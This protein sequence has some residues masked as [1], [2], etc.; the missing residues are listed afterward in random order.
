MK[1]ELHRKVNSRAAPD[2]RLIFQ[3]PQRNQPIPNG[4]GGGGTSICSPTLRAVDRKELPKPASQELR[5]VCF[6]YCD[7]D[8]D[9]GWDL[10]GAQ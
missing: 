10:R 8:D 3:P 1:T 5:R 7:D 6:C 9:V 4:G 2:K